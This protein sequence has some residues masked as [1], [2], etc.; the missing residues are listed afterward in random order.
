MCPNQRGFHLPQSTTM[1]VSQQDQPKVAFMAGLAAV[2]LAAFFHSGIAHAVG[3][4]GIN[5]LSRLGQPFAA[6]IELI[7]VSREDLATL[8]VQPAPPA[9]Y[10]AANLRFD[11]ALNALRLSVER[12]A[13]GTPYIRAS[14]LRRVSE[15]YLDVVVELTAQDVKVQRTYTALL[16]LPDAPAAVAITPAPVPVVPAPKAQ[17]AP[18]RAPAVPRAAAPT[19][20]T[21]TPRIASPARVAPAAPVARAPAADSAAL[22]RSAP[23][24]T[25]PKAAE[26]VQSEPA[27]PVAPKP[28]PVATEPPK[29]EAA[30][31]EPKPETGE[32]TTA[33]N[34]SA[35]PPA[36][37]PALAPTPPSPQPGVVE[38]VSNYAAPLAG[39]ALALL[40]AAA[41]LLAWRRRN[42]MPVA[43][44]SMV[45][46]APAQMPVRQSAAATVVPAPTPAK[47][48]A[49]AAE[50]EAPF[51]PMVASVTDTV[52]PLDEA[53]V[54]LEYGQ[55]EQAE[56]V[57]REALNQQPGREDIQMQLLEIVASRGDTDGFNQLAGRVHKQTGGLGE[58]WKRV[59]AMG[60]ALDPGYPLYSPT[61]EAG[62]SHVLAVAV[63][64]P[65]AVAGA[66]DLPFN[67]KVPVIDMEKTM[68]LA[69]PASAPAG[70]DLPR[71]DFEFPSA[72]TPA[73]APP[74]DHPG[75]DFKV[76]LPGLDPQPET[77]A[78]PAAPAAEPESQWEEVQKKIMLARAYREMGDTEGALELLREV[79]REG[80][81]SQ[82]AEMRDILQTLTQAG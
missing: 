14:S 74:E 53:R 78:S 45:A 64:A 56:R 43:E 40:A 52:D 69:R 57:L 68:V 60:Y 58:H 75:L 61:D 62:T 28:E 80:D 10:E 27:K 30:K 13:N 1:R 48:P 15:P 16:D 35:K 34:A 31:P 8:K 6:E 76:D 11:P 50:A 2:L 49:A 32:I 12:R 59:M 55:A 46:V 54:H 63:A 73:S 23:D 18:P 66:A 19:T 72:E 4:G 17:P 65:G 77:V 24:R 37:K 20:P 79:E 51:E 26:P 29:A 33:A 67:E 36:P 39:A 3:L 7:N 41:G 81:S 47:P 82:V 22:A 71:I 70:E 21:D 42:P 25:E 9:A 38:F 44:S 5:V